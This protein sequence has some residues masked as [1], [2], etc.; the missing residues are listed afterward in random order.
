MRKKREFIEGAAYHVTSRTNDKKR[1]FECN[2][3]RKTMLLFLENAKG[4]FGFRL[5]NFCICPYPSAHHS[6]QRGKPLADYA[7]DQDPFGETME[8]YTRFNRPPVR[9][10]YFARI[11]KD[12]REYFYVMDYIDRNPVK[13]GLVHD[14]GEGKT[15]GA[16]YIRHGFSGPG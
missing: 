2:V 9:E 3:G 7:L 10:R 12:P 16:Y 8:P 11:I 14:V 13:G 6:R 1:V 15:S 4:K 5:V